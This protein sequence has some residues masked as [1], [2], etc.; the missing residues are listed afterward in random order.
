MPDFR[1]DLEQILYTADAYSR[2]F[3]NNFN[4][5]LSKM[6]PIEIVIVT[7]ASMIILAYI[8]EK[9]SA[10]RKLGI[11]ALVFRFAIKLPFVKG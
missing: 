1:A 11:K 3:V 9:L 6:T 4:Q 5:S 2:T 8:S 10:W 7:I